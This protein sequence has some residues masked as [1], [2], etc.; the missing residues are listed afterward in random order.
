MLERIR[1]ATAH[2]WPLGDDA[3]LKQIERDLHVQPRRGKPG[4]PPK[5]S[6][7]ADG[8]P[9]DGLNGLLWLPLQQ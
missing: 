8:G 6:G 3:F 7:R 5:A 4:R 9:E 1:E 2:G